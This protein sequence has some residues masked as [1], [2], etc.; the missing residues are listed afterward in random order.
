MTSNSP[1][2]CAGT[3]LV[4]AEYATIYDAAKANK[5]TMFLEASNRISG[6]TEQI[7]S[8]GFIG[9]VF[10]PTDDAINAAL[11]TAGV[12]KDQLFRNNSLLVDIVQYH[13]VPG[14]AISTARLTNDGVYTSMRGKQLTI[15]KR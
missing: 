6:F 1:Q 9:T 2:T 7:K 8:P 4:Q 11:D 15:T 5:L 3:A 12:T 13:V 14:D 10:A